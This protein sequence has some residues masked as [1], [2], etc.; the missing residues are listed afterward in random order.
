MPDGTHKN[1]LYSYEIR[2]S[3]DIVIIVDYRIDMK[4]TLIG[5]KDAYYLPEI[6]DEPEDPEDPD[7]PDTPDVLNEPDVPEGPD[8]DNMSNKIKRGDTLD[9]VY[10]KIKQIYEDIDGAGKG[11]L[12]LPV[13]TVNI[14]E[15][16]M[17]YQDFVIT[18]GDKL[19]PSFV[20]N[21]ANEVVEVDWKMLTNGWQLRSG[22]TLTGT[23]YFRII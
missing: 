1:I 7:E 16:G 3:H 21:E 13:S 14:D 12:N 8:I 6:S 18:T 2:D 4:V 15:N 23:V 9:E 19:R 10:F 22:L 17:Y 20:I 5:N 11:E